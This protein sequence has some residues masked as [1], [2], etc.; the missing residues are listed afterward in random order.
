MTEPI[1]RPEALRHA[2]IFQ[3]ASAGI[4]LVVLSALSVSFAISF[5][6]FVYSGPL[7]AHLSAGVGL[8]LLGVTL[9]PIVAAFTS[10]YRGVVFH[11]QDVP[12][13]LLGGAA[14][15]VTA[16]MEGG[17]TGT[18]FATVA[19][20]IA[21]ATLVT[22]ATLFAAARL[23]LGL[24]ARFMPYPVIG[25]FLAATGFLLLTGALGM[26]VKDTVSVWNLAPL[27]QPGA[28][29]RWLPWL[30][31]SAVTVALVRTSDN[32]FMLP[33]ALLLGGLGFFGLLWLLGL[34]LGAASAAGLL[35][36]PFDSGNFLSG[37]SPDI[38]VQADWGAIVQ[39]APTVIAI[40][41]VSAMGLLLNASG[42]ELALGR[43][44]DF[45]RE[46]ASG[47]RSN[48]AAGLM[49]GFPGYH[50]MGE[51]LLAH[52]IGIT[53]VLAGITVALASV[54]TLWFGAKLIAAFPI[55]LAASVIAFLG[56]DLL[57]EWLWVQRRRLPLQDMAIIALILVT[58]ATL[59]FIEAL[60]VGLLAAALLFVFSYA[61]V[62]AVG[63]RTT[64]AVRRSAVERGVRQAA[65]LAE[66]GHRTRIYELRGYL[67][68]G[69][70]NRLLEDV[71]ADFAAPPAPDRMVF[72]LTRMT[73]LDTSATLALARTADLC[74][75]QGAEFVLC[76]LSDPVA[77][78]LAA[79]G[80]LAGI[81]LRKSLDEALT[82]IEA[83]I[84]A[85]L[86][87]E[88]LEHTILDAM[89]AASPDLD[90]GAFSDRVHL[91]AGEVLI[92]EG[93][94]ATELYQVTGG[95]L[96]AEVIG[97]DGKPRVVGRFLP[98][99]LIGEIA[100]YAGV[101]RTATIVVEHEA[102]LLRIQIDHIPRTHAGSTAAAVLHSY[103]ARSLAYRL[104]RMT[105]LV[106]N[107][108]I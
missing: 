19:T 23:R 51:T 68:F 28:L 101:P 46:L 78:R 44:I 94:R 10:S 87:D 5:A 41:G 84:L 63:L 6:A 89:A 67:F 107:A 77:E 14:I 71:R 13:V 60:S 39:Q 92:A 58:A 32:A 17:E 16:G 12:A 82:V 24:L 62:D 15:A 9:M 66:E 7:P 72:D 88:P 104:M 103:A 75:A 49:G 33:A 55:G 90:L 42:L 61:G 97:L 3:M 100:A 96:R 11:A 86:S 47:A 59:G 85:D 106:R 102:T 91:A 69:T 52:R 56:I 45:N 99:A 36:G 83:E 30:L 93:T 22:A 105:D 65:R 53:G 70:A 21:V 25:G 1:T 108:G 20:L 48:L 80:M 2:N 37:I 43:D 73:N 95:Q 40:A 64:G 98:G 38:L 29:V 26:M 35:L 54:L 27:W 57:Y 4:G 18:A 31:F 74:R 50:L 76:G 79:S 34:D 8:S 81:T